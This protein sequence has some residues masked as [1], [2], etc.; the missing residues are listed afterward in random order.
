MKTCLVCIA[1]NEDH[2]IQ[3]WI[4]Y[5]LKIGFHNIHI[6]ANDWV[7]NNS[8]SNLIIKHISGKNQQWNAYNSFLQEYNHSYDWAAFLDV[9][10]FLVL[11]K[12]KTLEDFLDS[13]NDCNAIGINWAIF[14]NNN[15]NKII[16]N[17]YSVLSRF[18]RRNKENH[19]TNKHVKTM[20]KLPS[21]L[22][23]DIHNIRGS[24]YNLKKEIRS[25]PFNE[26]VD[27]SVAKIHH[28]FT[29]SKEEFEIKCERGR[30]DM[31]QKREYNDHTNELYANDIEDTS[32]LNF[33]MTKG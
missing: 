29:K 20:V 2:Y 11:E 19:P 1:K 27:W 30:A 22:C 9:D 18:T 17:N 33:Y 8:Q 3:E 21:F 7:Y 16:N 15:H 13:Y 5:H 25:G 14:G 4:D 28:Y 32:A 6:Y 23:Q 31:N 24:W 10:E 12:H 26:P